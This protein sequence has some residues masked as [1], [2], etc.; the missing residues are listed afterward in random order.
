MNTV[1]HSAWDFD[2]GADDSRMP[3]ARRI[4]VAEQ[5]SMRTSM[6]YT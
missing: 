5:D 2:I 6:R 4:C 3:L 1:T